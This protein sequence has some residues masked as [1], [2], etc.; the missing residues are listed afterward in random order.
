MKINTVVKN[1]GF[2]AIASF[3]PKTANFTGT[4]PL[5]FYK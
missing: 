3:V 5:I 1:Y 2:E 4:Q